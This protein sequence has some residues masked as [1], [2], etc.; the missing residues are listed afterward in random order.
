[1]SS[2]DP[3]SDPPQSSAAGPH[4]RMP[5]YIAEAKKDLAE[6]REK[7][8]AAHEKGLPAS[9]VTARLTAAADVVV[10]RLW[11][12]A[13]D[14]SSSEQAAKLSNECVL[15]AHGG[16][17]RRQLAPHSDIDLMVLHSSAGRSQ[18]EELA[19]R[20]TSELFD[21]GLDLGH[22]VRTPE[23]AIQL[24]RQDPV[25]ATSLIE[26]RH[27]IGSQPLYERFVQSFRS[28]VQ[29]RGAAACADFIEARRAE[30][31]RYGE[32]VY[33]LEP[34]LKRSRGALRDLHLLKWLW[35]VQLGISDFDRI[36]AAGA[37]SKFDHHRLTSAREF[38]MRAR[39]ELHFASKSAGDMLLRHEQLRIAE[40]LGYQSNEGLRP[41]EGFMRD[42]F[43]HAGFVWFLTRRLSELTTRRK[44]VVQAFRPVL[45]KAIDK[46]YETTFGEIS[47]TTAYSSKLVGNLSEILHLLE[48]ARDH[49]KWIAQDTWYAIY[50]NAHELPRELT[51]EAAE[52]FMVA[53]ANKQGVAQYLRRAH[54]LT[55][56]ERV[57][58]AFR[59]VRCLLQF[60]QYH[61][62]TVDEHSLR[63]VD[64]ATSFADREDALGTTY[65]NLE[66]LGLLHLA[67][68][69]HDV[70]KAREGDHSIVGAEM[71]VEMA[72]R[73]GL[74][75]ERTKQLELL[76]RHHLTMTHL[77][78]RRDTSDPA[79]LADFAATVGSSE[80][81]S[82]LFVLTCADMAAVGPD[83]LND[84]KVKVLADLYLR[85]EDLIANRTHQVADRRNAIRN[86]VWQHLND[87]ER[88]D[89]LIKQLF[90]ALPESFVSSRSP[91]A[92]AG[93]LRRLLRVKSNE[94][95][96]ADTIALPGVDAWGR[97]ERDGTT[98]EMVAV[99][100]QGAGRGVFS[101]MAGALSSKGL[102]ILS[103]ETVI[104]P[105][106]LLLLRYAAT[107][108]TPA[109][110][111][112]EANRRI[113]AIATAV[114]HSVD[115]QEPPKIPQVW[116]A[117]K[118]QKAAELSAKPSEVRIDTK[119]SEECAII[120]VFAVDRAGML[121]ELARSLHDS[122]LVI[123]FAKISTSL[124]R[125]VDVFYVTDREN[126]KPTE[127]MLL[128]EVSRKLMDVIE[129]EG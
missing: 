117:D 72:G 71:A 1:M 73:L 16:Y 15:V 42:Y 51:E 107:D 5:A 11:R 55:V 61:K 52:R 92:L 50:R 62:F 99:V 57:I 65:N 26:S 53:L 93:V 8:R 19:R 30:R 28:S 91:G 64:A 100:A 106:N 23:Q 22:S 85:T 56:L 126:E 33:L 77:A 129:H 27:L 109:G 6:A 104:L 20:L 121:Y 3:R 124:D 115:S 96:P 88:D 37:L 125:V 97:Y 13:V 35:F 24:A 102:G 81:L 40:A 89:S 41:V 105:E 108:P 95:P 36:Q 82:M 17:G 44:S 29:R 47:A 21:V 94:V 120:E 66:D 2:T 119:V 58:P 80:N 45:T 63:A 46:N 116:G 122:G 113:R 101:S 9:Q 39:I 84:W 54:D 127:E 86:S 79:I 48:L 90:E 43:R 14:D 98:V 87:S 114:V 18:A 10:Q 7:I 38:M 83:V 70:G 110:N 74:S 78:F 118:A 75:E 68:L 76:V 128:G 31:G 12:E 69:L 103:A 32:T 111:A 49:D 34:N 112:A 4:N 67:L 25:I 60:N 123:R 59:E